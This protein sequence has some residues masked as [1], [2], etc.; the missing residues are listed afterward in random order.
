MDNFNGCS[1]STEIKYYDWDRGQA[2][3]HWMIVK[4][5]LNQWGRSTSQLPFISFLFL[6]WKFR[7]NH[8]STL[9]RSI[10]QSICSHITKTSTSILCATA[11]LMSS[12]NL[13]Q[14][15]FEVHHQLNKPARLEPL[16]FPFYSWENGVT[17]NLHIL[18]KV[19]H[20]SR[21]GRVRIWNE[22]FFFFFWPLALAL[23][24][25]QTDIGNQQKKDSFFGGRSLSTSICVQ[26]S[27]RLLCISREAIPPLSLRCY[28]NRKMPESQVSR[29]CP[30]T[31]KGNAS[32]AQFQERMLQCT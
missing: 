28:L 29:L 12:L 3:Y 32:R 31:V 27:Q 25:N 14:S 7:A 15:Q 9:E 23:T 21:K 5:N 24:Q 20:K 19:T 10:L 2:F 30:R 4:F 6:K 17:V 26:I 1:I 22:I 13:S 16:S 18:P 11:I 8:K